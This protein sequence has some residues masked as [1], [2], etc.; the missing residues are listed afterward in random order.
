MLGGSALGKKGLD[1]ADVGRDAAKE[2]ISN[3]AH[4][5]CVDEYMQVSYCGQPLGPTGSLWARDTGPDDHLPRARA[6]EI[7]GQDW[8]L[9]PPHKV[10][11]PPF[12]PYRNAKLTFEHV[13]DCH[14][15]RRAAV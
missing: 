12:L 5:G 3:L 6:G 13:Q 2:L 15:G 9:D 1:P 4:D 14:L 10:R 7:E 11:A 8:S